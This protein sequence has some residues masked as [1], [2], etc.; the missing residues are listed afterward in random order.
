[1]I[2]VFFAVA[3]AGVIIG[4]P[5]PYSDQ[6]FQAQMK[7]TLNCSA[8][9]AN[10]NGS[11]TSIKPTRAGMVSISTGGTFF[12]GVK[13]DGIDLGAQLKGQCRRS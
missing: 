9:R 8:F 3:S 2:S 6:A 11:W 7:V 13:L 4:S 12:P 10:Q 1:M 5:A